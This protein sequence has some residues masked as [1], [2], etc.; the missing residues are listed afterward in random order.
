MQKKRPSLSI[1]DEWLIRE[2]APLEEVEA[3][4]VEAVLGGGVSS[5]EGAA[6]AV[7]RVQLLKFQKW[8]N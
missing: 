4:M 2:K 1:T 7:S 5:P 6:L 3:L 8:N